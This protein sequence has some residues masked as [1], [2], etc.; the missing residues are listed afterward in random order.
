MLTGNAM[1]ASFWCLVYFSSCFVFGPW[2]VPHV[3]IRLWAAVPYARFCSNIVS[4]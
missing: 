3:R 1:L 4:L 2:D